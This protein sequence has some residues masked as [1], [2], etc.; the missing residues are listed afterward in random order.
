MANQQFQPDSAQPVSVLR[1]LRHR[2]LH[3]L[4]MLAAVAGALL[5][6]ACAEKVEPLKI[7]SKQFSE[8]KIL[9]EMMALVAENEG[10]PVSR[11]IPFGTPFENFEAIK[12][13]VIDV[14]PEYNGTG[15]VFLGQFPLTDGDASLARVRELFEPLGVAWK[16][17]FGL[18]NDYALV[19]KPD[20]AQALG[21]E[22]ISDLTK[23]D[24]GVRFAVDQNFT[25][26]PLD[27]LGAMVRRYGL[28]Q[29]TVASFELADEGK[30]KIFRSL[31]GGE[32]D[33]AEVY[34]TDGQIVDY[35][36]KVLQ[37]DLQFFPVYEPAPLVRTDAL[38]RFPKLGIAL[39]KLAGRIDSAA[40]Q[41]MNAAVD[42]DGRGY[43]D[44]SRDSLIDA[45]LLPESG[46]SAADAEELPVAAGPLDELTGTAGKMMQA[47]RSAYPGRKLK[48]SRLP[49]PIQMVISG[50]ARLA[51][52]G[53]EAFFGAA[54][55]LAVRT[56]AAEA[57]GVV[58]YRTAHLITRRADGPGTLS[59]MSK[60]AVGEFEGPSER[61]ARLMLGALGLGGKV[62][63]IK[64][65]DSDIARQVQD[66][67][68]GK[69]D[70]VFAMV[71]IGHGD[72][73]QALANRDL[74]LLS[75]PEWTAGNAAIRFSFM[76]PSKIPAGA[77]GAQDS[78][79]DSVNTQMVLVGPP[80]V[81]EELGGRGPATAGT[82]K[83]QPMN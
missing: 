30:E 11:S 13:G 59:E 56:A 27:G 26:R 40:M 34:T 17:R 79:V 19:M 58:G 80:S 7:G 69:V 82:A 9:A 25:E 32:S 33:V 14:Y 22:T 2:A 24:G 62:N 66:L 42:L 47:V 68:D 38:T 5:L 60:I 54:G 23:L 74:K 41:R 63:L 83:T 20:K 75:I 8:S 4:R 3:W 12:Q 45:G 57:V 6:G 71:P 64:S 29:G 37:D 16:E 55:D 39:D 31:L 46:A 76:R 65:L 15:L 21:I 18:A 78:A 51:L 73:T 28:T 44:V 67:I 77:Y 70:G 72:V 35:G 43:E 10:I 1:G 81:S 36:L 61:A 53:A 49:N 52:V 50:D 48:V